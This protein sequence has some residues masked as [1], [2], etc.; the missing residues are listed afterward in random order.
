MR[1]EWQ[2]LGFVVVGNWTRNSCQVC[3]LD[4]KSRMVLELASG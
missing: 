1:D 2:D 4:E 3:D